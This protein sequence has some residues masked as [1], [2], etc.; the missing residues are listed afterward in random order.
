MQYPI[1]L[2]V[3]YPAK[4]SRLTTFFRPIMLIPHYFLLYFISIAMGVI[5]F[6]SW[7]AILFTGKYPRAFFDFVV[8]SFRWYTRA[9]GYA[10]LLSDKYPPFS[11]EP[12][13]AAPP[14]TKD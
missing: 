2:N 9:G 5:V 10:N 14:Q 7:W 4:L 12:S 3:A 6:L 8:W 1:E 11:G 13:A